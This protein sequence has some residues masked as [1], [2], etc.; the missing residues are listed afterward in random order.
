MEVNI[1]YLTIQQFLQPPRIV[2]QYRKDDY[3][4]AFTVHYFQPSDRDLI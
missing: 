1:E 2:L 3:V 4:S